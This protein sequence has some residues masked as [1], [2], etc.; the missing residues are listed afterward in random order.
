MAEQ[1]LPPQQ[2]NPMPDA[3]SSAPLPQ[4]R[5]GGI[6]SSIKNLFSK[7]QP[8]PQTPAP[9]LQQPT[10]SVDDAAKWH[11]VQ[12]GLKTEV[13][14]ATVPVVASP[15]IT[16]DNVATNIK[17]F[18]SVGSPA[19]TDTLINPLPAPADINNGLSNMFTGDESGPNTTGRTAEPAPEQARLDPAAVVAAQE[20]VDT[21]N[22]VDVATL[23]ATPAA[24]DIP[25]RPVADAPPVTAELNTPAE[26]I[27]APTGSLPTADEVVSVAEK[28]ASDATAGPTGKIHDEATAVV[29]AAFKAPENKTPDVI[30]QTEAV[31]AAAD[32]N[33]APE[34]TGVGATPTPNPSGTNSGDS[35]N[36]NE[37]PT[38]GTLPTV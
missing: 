13:K 15:P 38:S 18:E 1:Q 22:Q 6:I 20:H 31:A 34:P 24:T 10:P 27:A 16:A 7:K 30:E 35:N 4:A 29:G 5:E 28:V 36:G 37:T 26:P 33:L 9:T 8:L 11:E 17:G 14:Q 21:L 2:D 23:E 3:T 12:E 32:N 25:A 19:T